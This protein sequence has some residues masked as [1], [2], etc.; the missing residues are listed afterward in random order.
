MATATTTTPALTDAQ[1][2][3]I[4]KHM[5]ESDGPGAV[6]EMVQGLAQV[7]SE[8]ARY[9]SQVITWQ[10]DIGKPFQPTQ[11]VA[12][13]SGQVLF[14]VAEAREIRSRLAALAKLGSAEAGAAIDPG[15]FPSAPSATIE[16]H[17][18]LLQGAGQVYIDQLRRE[19]KDRAASLTAR[20]TEALT[21]LKNHEAG[22]SAA[23]SHPSV[24]TANHARHV[25]LI[26]TRDTLKARIASLDALAVQA[27]K[28]QAAAVAG[29]VQ[30]TG[31]ADPIAVGVREARIIAG[32]WLTS[33]PSHVDVVAK[34]AAK[35]AIDQQLGQLDGAGSLGSG[36]AAD[37][38]TATADLDATRGAIDSRLKAGV[39][40][41]IVAAMAG[42]EPARS[43]IE[44]LARA[45][46]R[47]FPPGFADALAQAQFEYSADGS[48]ALDALQQASK[49]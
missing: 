32:Q 7:E 4:L 14:F 11:T 22:A 44:A 6:Q 31:G 33:D 40:A 36:L 2:D 37:L 18:I 43:G 47:A 48:T 13:I 24:H 10:R 8:A 23:G 41:Q 17:L 19:I 25:A 30:K 1:S 29:V 16:A 5:L 49:P 9:A 20:L 26:T 3:E 34:A 39:T 27:P 21:H 38:T 45:Q 35:G 12:S 42:D 28:F 46:P 15:G